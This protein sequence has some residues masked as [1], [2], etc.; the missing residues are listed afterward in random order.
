MDELLADPTMRE[1]YAENSP[2][3]SNAN[4]DLLLRASQLRG[5]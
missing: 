5:P 1:L 2:S 4:R 3:L